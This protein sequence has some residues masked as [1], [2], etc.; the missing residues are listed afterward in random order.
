MD[1]FDL[2]PSAITLGAVLVTLAAASTVLRRRGTR[3]RTAEAQRRTVAPTRLPVD[4][5]IKS[6]NIQLVQMDDAI[7][8]AD[9]ELEFARAEFGDAAVH[10]FAEALG[11]A[12][13]RASEAFALKQRLDDS[14]PDTEQEQRDWSKRI[15]SLSDAALALVTAQTR[16]ITDRRRAETA[17]PDTLARLSDRTA[18]ARTRVP[19][20][21]ATLA[22]LHDAYDPAALEAIEGADDR[23]RQALDAADAARAQA[24]DSLRTA[25]V[26]PVD[27]EVR[28]AEALLREAVALLDSVDRT[29]DALRQARLDRASALDAAASRLRDADEL[30]QKVADPDAAQRILD[31]E[32][33]MRDTVA[34]AETRRPAHPAADIDALDAAAA[35]LDHALATART[36]QQRLDSAREAL[37]GALA[38]AESHIRTASELISSR[39]GGVGTDARTRLAAAERELQ[40]ARLEADPVAALDGAR[41]AATLATDADA[42]ARYDTM[43][44]RR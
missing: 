3:Q 20:A 42:L 18:E 9:D 21:T 30:R 12:K 36:A 43:H 1:G 39:R 29:R 44:A 15:L 32:K 35:E 24:H 16:A 26:A 34:L 8:D 5:L 14:V 33:R 19:L 4:E 2:L 6:A 17:A 28:R 23:A 27:K 22:E 31:A 7:R 37:V 40:L 11:T 13:K 41:R 10:D 25:A 38:I